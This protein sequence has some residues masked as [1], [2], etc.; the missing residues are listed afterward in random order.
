VTAILRTEDRTKTPSRSLD[1]LAVAITFVWAAV[2]FTALYVV[3]KPFGPAVALRLVQRSGDIAVAGA[4]IAGAAGVGLRLLNRLHLPTVTPAERLG[5]GT[6]LGL[7]AV[8]LL[9]LALGLLGF[10]QPL[11]AL[12]I[13]LLLLATATGP[14]RQWWH[15][16]PA[17]PPLPWPLRLY[18][19]LMLALSLARVLVPATDWDG[20]SYHLTAPQRWIALGRI[21]WI[22]AEGPFYYPHVLETLF[23]PAM[24][25]RGDSAARVLHW[26]FYPLALWLVADLT[27]RLLPCVPPW[28]AVAVAASVPML[29]QLASWAYTDVAL[30]AL[31]FGA[32]L[33]V[34][35]GVQQ[36]GAWLGVGGALAGLALGMKYQ[37]FIVPLSLLLLLV[38]WHRQ[39]AVRGRQLGLFAI[40]AGLVWLPWPLRN[41][42]LT[43]DPF[44]PFGSLGR[45]WDAHRTA[46]F[47]A[48]GTGIGL[49]PGRLVLL[50]WSLTLGLDGIAV[51]DGRSG[52]L[53][54]A[55]LPLAFWFLARKY[56]QAA[57]RDVLGALLTV[58]AIHTLPWI[59][60]VIN[61][62]A[63]SQ[64]RFLLP[65]FLLLSPVIAWAWETLVPLATPHFQPAGLLNLLVGVALTLTAIDATLE[66]A[67]AAPAT[68]I[69]GIDQPEQYL[70]GHLG[71]LWSATE[72]VNHLPSTSRVLLLWEPRSYYLR[73][74][75][76]PDII[77]DEFDH[78][79]WLSH[80]DIATLV[81]TLHG[82]GVTH[83]LVFWAGVDFLENQSQPALSSALREALTRFLT[84]YTSEV[85]HAPD[86]SYAIYELSTP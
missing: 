12:T 34:L 43:G 63:T 49:D 64:S 54:L 68:A 23:L 35:V 50:P 82:E 58:A 4:L 37:A 62:A 15:A 2:V 41:L 11:V 29:A 57:E 80:G 45:G 70:A 74:P 56:G 3:Q 32:L 69:L 5:L 72:Q 36:P 71:S 20:L 51:Y 60:G 9:W 17:L 78:R 66:T 7:G 46:A 55:L 48:A 22:G 47:A 38:R 42:W 31:T 59:V 25:L 40:T 8:S 18:L 52:P 1:R 19:F 6:L 16:R 67:S 13:S 44:Y 76:D 30:V 83:V 79:L 85:W 77:L 14:L 33:V 21:G 73:R 81:R 65:V 28:R 53:F 84:G 27:R 10:L 26:V 75:S 24:L 39:S 61:S 86:G